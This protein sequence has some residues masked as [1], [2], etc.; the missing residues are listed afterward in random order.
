MSA[1]AITPSQFVVATA[2]AGGYAATGKRVR[3]LAVQRG[4]KA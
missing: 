2:A 4:R 3:T 1:A